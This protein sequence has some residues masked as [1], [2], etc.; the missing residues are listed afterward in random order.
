MGASVA[1]D[2]YL[3]MGDTNTLAE[4]VAQ[5]SAQ[6][7]AG[8]G[9]DPKEEG[10]DNDG[11]EAE[12]D[13]ES[14]DIEAKYFEEATEEMSSTLSDLLLRQQ[15]ELRSSKSTKR[16]SMSWEISAELGEDEL[17]ARR[18]MQHE[19]RQR[20]R[21]LKQARA[22]KVHAWTIPDVKPTA[23]KK[24]NGRHP[25][26]W[27]NLGEDGAKRISISTASQLAGDNKHGGRTK[28]K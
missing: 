23:K 28:R 12:G 26:N 25:A 20:L 13:T 24:S 5:M 9:D 19:E 1:L 18:R 6:D 21:R 3:E 11:V 2:T 10:K 4:L 16:H 8:K 14:G 27:A 17:A 22:G 7:E 15:E